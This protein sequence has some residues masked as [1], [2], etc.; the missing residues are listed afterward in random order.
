MKSQDFLILS[1]LGLLFCSLGR[2]TTDAE[3]TAPITSS[4]SLS[5]IIVIQAQDK[6]DW[7]PQADGLKSTYWH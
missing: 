7:Y 2:K 5:P 6:T 3:K 4:K 1:I